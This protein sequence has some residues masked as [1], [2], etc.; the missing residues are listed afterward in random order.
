MNRQEADG[1]VESYLGLQPRYDLFGKSLKHLVSSVLSAE[2]IGVHSVAYRTKD[3]DH[4]RE[5]LLRP[6]KSYGQLLDVT[7]L[8]GLRVITYFEDDVDRVVNILRNELRVS[9]DHSVDKRKVEDATSFGYAS[10]HLVCQLSEARS[11]LAEYRQFAGMI[12]EIQVRSILQHTWAEIEHDLG[13]KAERGIPVPIRRRFSMLAGLFELADQEFIRLRND[14]SSYSLR[15]SEE[16]VSS[17]SNV[18]IDVVSFSAFVKSN[19]LSLRLDEVAFEAAEAID[20]D[21]DVEWISRVLEKLDYFGI[22]TIEDLQ[23]GLNDNREAITRLLQMT[24]S[25][26]DYPSLPIGISSYYLTLVLLG[27]LPTM[28][29]TVDGIEELSIGYGSNAYELAERYRTAVGGS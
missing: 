17:P 26:G 27:R 2:S 8:L 6:G 24:F 11:S 23:R 21:A 29:A 9:N 1:I 10:V 15:V 14:L 19:K 16:L 13:Y 20:E 22:R 4:L 5:K 7:D 12:C 18:L 28:A 25:P 3:P